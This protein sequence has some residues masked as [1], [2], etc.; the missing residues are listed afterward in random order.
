M[1]VTAC[2][3]PL[4]TSQGFQPASLAASMKWVTASATKVPEPQEGSSTRCFSGSSTSSSIMART[5]H[6]GV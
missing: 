2:R 4:S 5:S 1:P 3:S 6:A